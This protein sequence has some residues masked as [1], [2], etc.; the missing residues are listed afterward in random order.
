MEFLLLRV[1]GRHILAVPATQPQMAAR[2]IPFLPT[3]TWR[4]SGLSIFLRVLWAIGAGQLVAVRTAVLPGPAGCVEWN[5]LLSLCSKR[6]GLGP[7]AGG[8]VFAQDPSRGRSYLHLFDSQC[9]QVAFAKL[10]VAPE[11]VSRLKQEAKTLEDLAEHRWKCFRSPAPLGIV[12]AGGLTALLMAP[13]PE[14]SRQVT[15]SAFQQLDAARL[16][17][18]GPERWVHDPPTVS[19]WPSFA[20]VGHLVPELTAFLIAHAQCGLEV[21]CAHG[22]YTNWNFRRDGSRIWVFDWEQYRTDAPLLTDQVRFLLGLNTRRTV[23]ETSKVAAFLEE[24][25]RGSLAGTPLQLA[26]AL[27]FL[28]AGGVREATRVA[29]LWPPRRALAW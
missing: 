14:G 27:A 9:R 17:W 13:L 28:H 20:R 1:G 4:T 2:L 18:S 7:L 21:L 16:E 29:S 3:T 23:R 24:R 19:W 15:A 11:S 12:S 5:A 22:D 25:V 10:A 6:V 26:Y 8:V